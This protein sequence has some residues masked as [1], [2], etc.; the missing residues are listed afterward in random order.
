MER[1]Q[2]ICNFGPIL[3][4][5]CMFS[6]ISANLL[7]QDPLI[8]QER[9]TIYPKCQKKLG[10]FPLKKRK[11]LLTE[12][13]SKEYCCHIYQIKAL[14]KTYLLNIVSQL[15]VFRCNLQLPGTS[16][17]G[18]GNLELFDGGNFTRFVPYSGFWTM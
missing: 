2:T 15:V 18:R 16:G 11:T 8:M 5:S 9:N 4:L 17:R 7:P 10:V 13:F 14:V 6:G 1:D 12:D 3:F